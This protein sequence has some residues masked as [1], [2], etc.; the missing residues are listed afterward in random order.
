MNGHSLNGGAQHGEPQETALL[1]NLLL[2]SRILHGLGLE[3]NPGRM[4]E[5]QAAFVHVP[6]VRKSDFYHTLRTFLVKRKQDL[7]LFDQAFDLFWRKPVDEGA[8]FDLSTLFEE[9]RP[10]IQERLIIPPQPSPDEEEIPN[11]RAMR[12]GKK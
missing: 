11:Q 7:P 3:V 8:T 2:F 10:P 12:I 6:I 4:I 1:H 5:V 9:E